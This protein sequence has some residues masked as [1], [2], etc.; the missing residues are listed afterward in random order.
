MKILRRKTIVVTVTAIFIAFV[1][2]IINGF[3]GNPISAYYATQA[4]VKY[5][6]E[7]YPEFKLE[8]SKATYHAKFSEYVSL[9]KSTT[10]PDLHFE[11]RYK[12]AKTQYD[13]YDSDVLTGYN[14][15]KRFGQER[16]NEIKPLLTAKYGDKLEERC[17]VE[18]NEE[19]GILFKEGKVK[20]NQPYYK[21]F[22]CKTMLFADFSMDTVTPHSIETHIIELN[23]FLVDRGYVIDRLIGDYLDRE[24]QGYSVS[25]SK[26]MINSSLDGLIEKAL[27]NRDSVPHDELAIYKKQ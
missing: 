5:I 19:F 27:S 17:F 3:Y 16:T 26:E 9:A 11:V 6:K 21:D 7:K 2:F 25:I 13:Y 10:L 4:N 18:F 24:M 23:A 8:V 1:F 12:N 14:T 20:I 15:E 22:K